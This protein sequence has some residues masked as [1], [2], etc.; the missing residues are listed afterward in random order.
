MPLPAAVRRAAKEAA[1]RCLRCVASMPPFALT[2]FFL[3]FQLRFAV[4]YFRK[5]SFV[6]E[7][8]VLSYVAITMRYPS[9]SATR[10]ATPAPCP[11]ICQRVR[12]SRAVRCHI[13]LS[14]KASRSSFFVPSSPFHHASSGRF[15]F[16]LLHSFTM[17]QAIAVFS[18]LLLC[19]HHIIDCK[20]PVAVGMENRCLRI[21][22]RAAARVNRPPAFL[23]AVRLY[24][25]HLQLMPPGGNSVAS[26]A[27][28][29]HFPPSLR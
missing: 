26:P 8:R 12:H 19:F 17:R 6:D 21:W 3:H 27:R 9:P 15:S 16:L 23:H 1:C 25:H 14:G 4:Y 11:I 18:S 13:A 5:M 10:G 29:H 22:W 20:M 28:R 7:M 2:P 24:L